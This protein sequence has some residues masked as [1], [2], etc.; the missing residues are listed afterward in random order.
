MDRAAVGRSV[1]VRAMRRGDVDATLFHALPDAVVY[2]SHPEG[3]ILDANPAFLRLCGIA[4][5]EALASGT[6][7]LQVD[8]EHGRRF[9]DLMARVAAQRAPST[10]ELALRRADGST[11]AAQVTLAPHADVADEVV[12]VVCIV[13]EL[14]TARPTEDI[15]WRG[16]A[17]SDLRL[18]S[19]VLESMSEGV[20]LS[21]EDGII[22]YTNPAEDAMFGYARGELIGKPVTVQNA[23]PPGENERIVAGILATLKEKGHW[24]GEFQNKRKDGSVFTT[25]ARIARIE[26]EGRTRWVCVQEDVTERNRA[27]RELERSRQTLQDFV[28]TSAIGLHWVGPD[29]T[30]LW[31]N[32]A[33][34]ALLG[35]EREEYVG[36]DIR[37]FHADAPVI[38]DILTRLTRD[39]RLHD[40]PA[41]L[42]AKD[43]S[44]RHVLIDSSVYREE[45]RFIHTRCFTRDV[46]AQRMAEEKERANARSLKTLLRA[47]EELARS[48]DIERVVQTAT[49][50]CTTISGAQ[51][52]AFLYNVVDAKGQSSMLY[53]L[54]GAPRDA[55][56]KFPLPRDTK[57]FD[58]TFA[59]KGIV[60]SDD[61]TA[62]PRYGQAAPRPGT[63]SEGLPL[64]S[65]LAVP[66]VSRDGKVHGGIFL[67][68]SHTGRFTKGSE[69]LVAA[70]ATQIAAA[71]DNASLYKRA[72]DSEE[73]YRN[74]VAHAPDHILT[75]GADGV[76]LDVNRSMGALPPE[77]IRG[78]NVLDVIVPDDRAR[79]RETIAHVIR[80]NSAAEY[81][82]RALLDGKERWFHV[83]VAPLTGEHEQRAI[84]I[85]TDVTERKASEAEMSRVRAQLMQGE[86]LS[87]LGSLV[88]GVAHELRTPLTFL[89]NNVFLLK[90][91]LDEAANRGATAAE[92][93][94]DASR[95]LH[96]LTAGVERIDQLVEDL[97]RYTR[98]GHA[99]EHEVAPLNDMIRDA[100]EIFRATNRHSH[101]VQTSLAAPGRIRANRG[102]LQQL[103]LNL[104]QNAAEA[105]PP[106][107][108]IRLA[109]M[110]T[111]SQ[112][113]LEV[114][115]TG[116]GIPK[117]VQERMFEPL[118]TTKPAGTGL[119]LSIVKRIVDE[120]HA[121]IRCESEPG[122][123][124]TFRVL[125]PRA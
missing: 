79:V 113:V 105:T 80:T 75:I 116:Q 87:A 66:V 124:A 15:R 56:E 22:E 18:H 7:L 9:R 1:P 61:I 106:G 76:I 77:R 93:A 125:F 63:S 42:K 35:Y 37:E 117:S 23:Y 65:Y 114:T 19:K 4:S 53:T 96:E 84:L 36:R 34:H 95:F 12:G 21:T 88:S 103:V 27:L 45:G 11:F 98:A 112:V 54:S 81:E 74:L 119:G 51:F 83:R 25:Y 92:A 111:G 71:I 20:T 38:E 55:F 39:E 31:A 2:A 100:I 91:R 60:R 90:R 120:H 85:S 24:E 58:A 122:H 110:D 82:A 107:G 33:D 99:S 67:G 10:V 41:R 49:D 52:G 16:S 40:Y 26:I 109:T 46:T 17:G 48:L 30:I 104:L 57:V 29:G 14:A 64:R 43:G 78:T 73:R 70:V 102:A 13:R 86:K 59:G 123:G 89:S 62:D 3:R 101:V 69:D 5:E 108:I 72:K 68:H 50:A 115:D 32:A 47:Q 121:V 118:F 44:I 94:E 8:G 6:E 28:D 97:R